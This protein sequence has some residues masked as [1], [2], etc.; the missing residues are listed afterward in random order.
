MGNGKWV[1]GKWVV[2]VAFSAA[3]AAAEGVAGN[4]SIAIDGPP[5][6]GE[7]TASLVLK[8]DGK[9]VSGTLATDHA[10]A[11][12][13]EGEFADGTLTLEVASPNGDAQKTTM[14]AKVK[15]DGTLAGY[16]SGPM[17]DMKCTGK[18]VKDK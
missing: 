18:R 1:M 3:L 16:L 17:G 12:K 6:H 14:T 8:Q 5:G 13:V 4:W 2:I 10:G 7:M 15:E 11:L 9:K